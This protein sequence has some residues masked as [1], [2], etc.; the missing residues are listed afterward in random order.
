MPRKFGGPDFAR[1]ALQFEI[2]SS[3]IEALIYGCSRRVT[4]LD[5]VS[6]RQHLQ[7]EHV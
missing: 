5:R 6:D 4:R 7:G 1:G 3:M 2:I